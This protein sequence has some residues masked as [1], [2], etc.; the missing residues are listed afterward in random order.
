MRKCLPSRPL[1]NGKREEV[2]EYYARIQKPYVES[3]CLEP[4]IDLTLYCMQD[5]QVSIFP[6]V[7]LWQ[8][9]YFSPY[10]CT[11]RSGFCCPIS[12]FV[13]S[14]YA[15]SIQNC[16]EISSLK[17][18]LYSTSWILWVYNFRVVTFY[19][20][21]IF[22]Y[23]DRHAECIDHLAVVIEEYLLLS[24]LDLLNH[25]KLLRASNLVFTIVEV[26]FLICL[27]KKITVLLRTF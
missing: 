12:P 20:T 25:P 9:C 15:L 6:T 16:I 11:R 21:E 13:A 3:S 19:L 14:L 18:V 4:N 2:K 7:L 5:S 1:W 8:D 17:I 22:G 23:K 24:L 26:I 10:I 27:L